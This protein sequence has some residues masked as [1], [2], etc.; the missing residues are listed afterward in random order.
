VLLNLGDSITTDHISPAGKIARGS[1]AARFLESNNVNP[2]DFNSY[3]ARRGNDL[4]MERGTFA[5]IRIFN[6]LVGEAGPKT[7][8]IPT[9]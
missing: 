4:V 5:N 6:K 2:R 1:P 9:D 7:I 8:H 3:G